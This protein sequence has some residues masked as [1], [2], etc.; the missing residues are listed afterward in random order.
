MTFLLRYGCDIDKTQH[1]PPQWFYTVQTW[2]GKLDVHVQLIQDGAFVVSCK[3]TT[4][5][6]DQNH[7][8]IKVVKNLA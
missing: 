8:P 1:L 6:D 3:K 2:A 4:L 7:L 5:N